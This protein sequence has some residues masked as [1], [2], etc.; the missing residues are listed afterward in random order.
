M[1]TEIELP[2]L[3][4]P[5]KNAK[6]HAERLTHVDGPSNAILPVAV[7][8]PEKR[9]SVSHPPRSKSRLRSAESEESLAFNRDP[10]NKPELVFTIRDG[11]L[12]LFVIGY[13]I[14]MLAILALFELIMPVFFTGESSNKASW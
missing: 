2:L 7:I 12:V 8:S 13:I 3:E 5:S 10:Y 6:N 1:T 11:E 9:Q 14:A 4:G